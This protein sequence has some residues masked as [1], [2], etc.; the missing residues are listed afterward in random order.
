MRARQH[1]NHI[2]TWK[3]HVASTST[4]SMVKYKSSIS[5]TAIKD[6]SSSQ[7]L[8]KALLLSIQHHSDK[9]TSNRYAG[10]WRIG[11][12]KT[13]IFN[14]IG[15][16]SIGK[17]FH[18]SPTEFGINP[19]FMIFKNWWRFCRRSWSR[20]CTTTAWGRTRISG[21][22]P[23]QNRTHPSRTRP[24]WKYPTNVAGSCSILVRFSFYAHL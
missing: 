13:K 16:K 1:R 11:I 5:V 2:C 17:C 21:S 15:E 10:P 6:S 4:S 8:L 14:E 23:V 18:R 7:V 9:F 22:A 20:T 24:E 12:V 19:A 3:W